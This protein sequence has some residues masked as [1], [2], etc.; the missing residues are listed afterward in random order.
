MKEQMAKMGQ[1]KE[2]WDK[3]SEQLEKKRLEWTEITKT[4]EQFARRLKKYTEK[5]EKVKGEIESL[6][7]LISQT[8]K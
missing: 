2:Q 5:Y 7:Q 6:E 3:L 4:R 1:Y 8:D